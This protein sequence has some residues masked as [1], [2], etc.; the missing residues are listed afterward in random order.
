MDLQ[1]NLK[2][3]NYDTNKTKKFLINNFDWSYDQK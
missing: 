1:T 2:V 3:H